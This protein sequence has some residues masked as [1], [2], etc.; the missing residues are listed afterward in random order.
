MHALSPIARG[1]WALI[2][3]ELWVCGGRLKIEGTDWRRITGLSARTWRRVEQEVLG[4][5]E[6]LEGYIVEPLMVQLL[7]D[8][9]EQSAKKRQAGVLSGLARTAR[10]QGY[11]G[12]R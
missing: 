9:A 3:D 8:I 5:F 1:A 11:N 6:Q 12:S 4:A 7:A 10:S 2:Y